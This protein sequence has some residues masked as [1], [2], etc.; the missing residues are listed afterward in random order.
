[1]GPMLGPDPAKDDPPLAVGE[2]NDRGF[3]RQV[4]FA[5]QPAAPQKIPLGKRDGDLRPLVPIRPDDL[6]DRVSHLVDRQAFGGQV[7]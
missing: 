4:R 7:A 3:A 5:D 6:E 1:M 2:R